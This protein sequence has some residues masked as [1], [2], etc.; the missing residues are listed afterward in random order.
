MNSPAYFSLRVAQIVTETPDSRS[1]VFEV[2]QALSEQFAYK[3]GQFLTLR[4]PFEG[5]W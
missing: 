5:G 1:L 3:S 4:V 2:P